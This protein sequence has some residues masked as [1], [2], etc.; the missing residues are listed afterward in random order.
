MAAPYF[1]FLAAFGGYE[2]AISP[3]QLVES[4]LIINALPTLLMLT[5]LRQRV[6]AVGPLILMF[7]VAGLAGVWLAYDFVLHND[8][9]FDSV[10]RLSEAL[11]IGLDVGLW[12]ASAFG[13]LFIAVAGWWL[14]RRFGELHRRKRISDQSLTLD[15]L[16]AL[17]AITTCFYIGTKYVWVGLVAFLT[18][19]LITWTGLKYLMARSQRGS[20]APLLLLLRVFSLG[21]RSERLFDALAKRWRHVGSIGLIAGPDLI[22]STVKPDEFLD[23]LGRK[24]SRR[25]VSGQDDLEK[26]ALALDR[27]PDPDGRYRAAARSPCSPWSSV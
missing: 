16:F 17:F 3:S 7:M 21:K 23:F 4:W 27:M 13:F 1:L 8:T 9:L 24:L 14:L 26:R 22:R 12:S 18:Y 11:G 10:F 20:R 25:F 2:L 19:K 6:R 5:F 15:V